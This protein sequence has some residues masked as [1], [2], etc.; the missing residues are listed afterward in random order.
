MDK[1]ISIII[2]CYNVENYVG[3][4]IQSIFRQTLSNFEVILVDDGSS[5]NTANVIRNLIKNHSNFRYYYKLNGGLSDARNY[6]I[7]KAKGKYIWFV[8]GDDCLADRALE[9]MVNAAESTEAD[10]VGCSFG[11]DLTTYQYNKT[12]PQII[13]KD[14][15]ID[16]YLDNQKECEESVCNK[17][18]LRDLF[19]DIQFDYGKL[20]EDTFILYKLLEK[21]KKYC[22]VDEQL[23]NVISRQGSITRTVYGDRQYDKVEACSNIYQFYANSIHKQKAYNKYF[24][25]LTYFVLKT[26]YSKSNVNKKAID[27]LKQECNHLPVGLKTKFWPLYLLI[28]LNLIHL[29]KL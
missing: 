2:P 15:L 3:N 4:T 23:Y 27:E 11:Y 21:A 22:F 26:N 20:H 13:V 6:G 17:I 7:T 8:D 12:T 5:D 14:R 1:L 28:K 9:L 18:F 19:S 24:G 10:I 25:T 16:I 29:I